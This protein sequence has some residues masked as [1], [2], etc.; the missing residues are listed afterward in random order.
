MISKQ[1]L[2]TIKVIYYG[3]GLVLFSL[4]RVI[5]SFKTIKDGYNIS[6]ML[7]ILLLSLL[8]LLL[9]ATPSKPKLQPITLQLNWKYQFEFAGY[10]AAK[11]KGFYKEL[12]L[13]VTL[14][15]YQDGSDIVKNVLSGDADFG[16]YDDDITFLANQ[17]Q[18]IIWLQNYLKRP[19]LALVVKPN[20]FTPKDLIGKKIMANKTELETSAIGLMLKK[21]SIASQ[22]YI[23]VKETYSIDPFVNGEIDAMTVYL[24]NE[25]YALNNAKI[26]Y[27]LLDPTA[28]NI[29]SLGGNLFTSTTMIKQSES[30]V[31]RF[32]KATKKGWEYALSHP[33]ELID[34]IYT[35]YS[36]KK[37]IAALE[38]EADLISRLIM[39]DF[40]PL[41]SIDINQVY[42]NAT[43]LQQNG[44]ITGELHLNDYIYQVHDNILSSEEQAYLHHKKQITMCIDPDWMPFEKIQNSKHIGMTSDYFKLFSKILNISITLVP[45]STWSES[46][47]FAKARQCDIFSLAMETPKRKKYM[48]FTSAYISMPLVLATKNDKLFISDV[49]K[50]IDK[51]I[52]IIKDYAYGEILQKRY[53]HM[54]LIEVKNIHEG[55]D[56]VSKSKLYGFADSLATISYEIQKNFP[57]E[58]KITGKFEEKF[59]LAVA[60]RNDE[61]LLL[62]IFEKAITSLTPS[63]HQAILNHWISVN[64]SNNNDYTLIWKILSIALFIA[65]ILS[66]VIGLQ[67]RQN[68]LLSQAHKE[69]NQSL[70]SFITLFNSTLEGIIISKDGTIIEVNDAMCDILKYSKEEIV[71]K[72][73][74]D[75]V[76]PSFLDSTVKKMK[77][78]SNTPY[79][80]NIIDGRNREIPILFRAQKTIF[81]GDEVLII[82]VID[83]T[84]Q[85]EQQHELQRINK[86]LNIMAT[87]DQL[88]GLANRYLFESQL[89]REIESHKRHHHPL[90]LFILDI[91]FFKQVNDTHGHIVGDYVLK[92]LTHILKSS[93]RAEDLVSRWGGEEFIVL[94]PHSDLEDAKEIAERFR[95]SISEHIFKEVGRITVSIGV[96]QYSDKIGSDAWI[97]QADT[98]LYKAKIEG[99]NRVVFN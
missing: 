57:G 42:K 49:S 10:I 81:K 79:E 92:E 38:Y 43:F 41:G 98:Y 55:L 84:Q 47:A 44:F 85:K 60:T 15:E 73:T 66:T 31:Q 93:S 53:P 7:K 99:R 4:K 94:L 88:T 8:P 26:N 13:D 18:P 58:L 20:I 72:T 45:T 24:S 97:S 28:Y 96:A 64:F 65:I 34:I 27:N 33:N 17:N 59:E 1:P 16:I 82:A 32:M 80:I 69:I 77:D 35:R 37:S 52:G 6:T 78:K 63:Q 39:P 74:L 22:D 87:H 90:S 48:D 91:D 21:F 29:H 71:Q 62:S 67:R 2:I 19:A 54:Q 50:I 75:F 76:A 36:A 70:N 5:F 14:K 86:K 9:F 89:Q 61:P 23:H 3:D 83:L 95:I 30:T 68:R 51:K 11:E 25:L 12:G 40:Y 46:I 56:A